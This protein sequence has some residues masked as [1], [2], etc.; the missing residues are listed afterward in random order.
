M[1]QTI[2]WKNAFTRTDI[3]V[4]ITEIQIWGGREYAAE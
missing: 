1:T 2:E 4:K 3:N